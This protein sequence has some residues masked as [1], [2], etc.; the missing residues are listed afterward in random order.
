MRKNIICLRLAYFSKHTVFQLYPFCWERNPFKI[1]ILHCKL[2]MHIFWQVPRWG[3]GNARLYWSTTSTSKIW[4][5]RKPGWGTKRISLIQA[6]VPI[7]E[8]KSWVWV[9]GALG[10][11]PASASTQKSYSECKMDWVRLWHQLVTWKLGLGVGQ[12][13]LSC[14]TY[15]WELK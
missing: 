10:S 2:E 11:D 4:A 14:S 7:S 15:W 1:R 8:G 12:A 5:A 3:I 9:Q 6:V 13:E